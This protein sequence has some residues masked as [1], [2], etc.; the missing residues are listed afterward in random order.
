MLV[1]NGGKEKQQKKLA[2]LR[3]ETSDRIATN[4]FLKVADFPPRLPFFCQ[5]LVKSGSVF[6]EDD[7]DRANVEA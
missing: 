7:E 1:P 4:H 5:D 3:S 6:L 2:P